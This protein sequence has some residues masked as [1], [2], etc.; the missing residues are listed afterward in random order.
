ME[1]VLSMLDT[2]SSM[3]VERFGPRQIR[4]REREARW[5]KRCRR[6]CDRSR[7]VRAWDRGGGTGRNGVPGRATRPTL[8]VQT[9]ATLKN[10]LN[11]Y[12]A[13]FGR[14]FTGS[15]G[16]AMSSQLLDA[17][18]EDLARTAKCIGDSATMLNMSFTSGPPLFGQFGS[19]A[20]M[21]LPEF[22]LTLRAINKAP[23]IHRQIAVGIDEWRG[24][25]RRS[26]QT[27]IHGGIVSAAMERRAVVRSNATGECLGG[28]K[29][30]GRYLSLF[31][32]KN[33]SCVRGESCQ[34]QHDAT[35]Q[36]GSGGT[37]GGRGNCGGVAG[38]GNNGGGRSSASGNTSEGG[39]GSG[40]GGDFA[41]SHQGGR[42]AGGGGRG[43]GIGG[44]GQAST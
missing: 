26:C 23:G 8:L 4:G 2:L 28:V 42:G 33:R 12:V 44:G 38:G 32:C 11:A 17:F 3:R 6:C 9:F 22:A 21:E 16:A 40:H 37:S 19:I 18:N 10:E 27:K 13:S 5:R 14:I 25:Q 1:F 36:G 41:Q 30:S 7:P 29:V 20:E 34:L 15:F 39:S 43:D 31:W 24:G 35:R